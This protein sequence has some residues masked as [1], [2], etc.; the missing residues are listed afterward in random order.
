MIS[1]NELTTYVQK[2]QIINLNHAAQEL[3]LNAEFLM[4]MLDKLVAKGLIKRHSLTPNCGVTCTACEVGKTLVYCWCNQT[5][6]K[7][8]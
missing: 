3:K 5:S 6:F 7:V 4:L 1:L 2:K 8:H